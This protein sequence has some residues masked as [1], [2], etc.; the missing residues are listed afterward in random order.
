MCRYTIAID[1]AVIEQARPAFATE[2][3]IEPWLQHQMEQALLRLALVTRRDK[4]TEQRIQALAAADPAT[5]S[6]R[7]LKGILSVPAP[8][9]E[10]LRDEYITEK[11]G[12]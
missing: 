12:V 8:S 6:F 3:D 4:N 1:D 10:Q 11:Y 9:L 5:V 7:D 2:S